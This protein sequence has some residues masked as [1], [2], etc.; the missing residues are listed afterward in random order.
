MQKIKSALKGFRKSS[1]GYPSDPGLCHERSASKSFFAMLTN[2]NHSRR[3]FGIGVR[4]DTKKASSARMK[5]MKGSDLMG[6]AGQF[7]LQ[8]SR[9]YGI[10]PDRYLRRISEGS[11]Q[12][13]EELAHQAENDVKCRDVS[14]VVEYLDS[15]MRTGAEQE[16]PA[17]NTVDEEATSSDKAPEDRLARDAAVMAARVEEAARKAVLQKSLRNRDDF[18]QSIAARVAEEAHVATEEPGRKAEVEADAARVSEM[19][20]LAMEEVNASVEGNRCAAG[21]DA[22]VSASDQCERSQAGKGDQQAADFTAVESNWWTGLVRT[23]EKTLA[24]VM[25]PSHGETSQEVESVDARVS[26]DAATMAA[27]VEE[28]VRKARKQDS[29]RRTN[30]GELNKEREAATRVDKDTRLA[31]EEVA[32]PTQMAGNARAS[33]EKVDSA[34]RDDADPPAEKDGAIVDTIAVA[35]NSWFRLVMETAEKILVDAA[36]PSDGAN[37]KLQED[38]YQSHCRDPPGQGQGG[39][40]RLRGC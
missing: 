1:S 14:Q 40:Q 25:Q 30:A 33:K 28:A 36:Q 26:R 11:E 24:R 34:V 35:V 32:E 15:G 27:R 29:L 5:H 16:F 12:P 23:A 4:G 3:V 21:G 10:G 13:D 8:G 2:K 19:P 7:K 20:C 37:G 6:C 39:P 9:V 17:A 18:K 22:L 38:A 31:A